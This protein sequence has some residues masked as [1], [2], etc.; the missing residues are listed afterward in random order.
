MSVPQSEWR[1]ACFDLDGTLVVGTSV[2]LHLADKLGHLNLLRRLEDRYASGE[3]SNAVVAGELGPYYAGLSLN[4]IEG[5]LSDVPMIDGV[6]SVL[7]T[8][9]EKGIESLICTVSWRFVAQM[10][11]KRYGFVD[12]SGCELP[13]DE[14]GLLGGNVSK[15]FDEYDKLDFVKSYCT[16]RRI[17]LSQVFAVGDSRSDIPLFGAVGFSVALNATAAAK[18]A[19]SLAIETE[20]LN[21]VL[22]VVPGLLA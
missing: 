3:I 6:P 17:P 1:L 13:V 10:L 8:L 11:A 22:E 18:A 7:G 2:C 15:H 20:D 9:K 14:Q 12:A 16:D 21:S 5:H 19:A 4:E